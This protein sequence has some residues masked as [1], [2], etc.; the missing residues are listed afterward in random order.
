MITRRHIV[1]ALA[2]LTGGSTR[3]GT[4]AASSRPTETTDDGAIKSDEGPRSRGGLNARDFGARGD[5]RTDDTAALQAFIDAVTVGDYG[6]I[7]RGVY[8]VTEPLRVG[9][10]GEQRSRGFT[11]EGAGRTGYAPGHDQGGTLILL[12]TGEPA[13]AI[14]S[15]QGS[16]WRDAR[17]SNLGLACSQMDMARYGLLI[18][19]SEV[20]N[21]SFEHLSVERAET[22]FGHLQG[23]GR[24]GEFCSWS[25]IQ[26][27]HVKNF[28]FSDAGQALA[29]RFTNC[30]CYF[31][32]GGVLF[33]FAPTIQ[34][35]GPR[36]VNFDASPTQADAG[37][38][39]ADTTLFSLSDK[40]RA[41][42]VMVGGRIEH[43][44][45]IVELDTPSNNLLL[46]NHLQFIGCDFTTD[47]IASG[48][49]RG[50][51]TIRIGRS[52]LVSLAFVNC[53]FGHAVWESSGGIFAIAAEEGSRGSIRFE[54]C[55]FSLFAEKPRCALPPSSDMRAI[56]NDCFFNVMGQGEGARSLAYGERFEQMIVSRPRSN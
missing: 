44:T 55:G 36:L 16:A 31:R 2:L 1:S 43:I 51:A 40:H 52:S 5:G 50:R 25:D 20:S 30:F 27:R 28:F 35:G 34:G 10:S 24:N 14:I 23:E 6:Y 19:S 26:T 18:V 33:R 8:R 11:I 45:T 13:E 49:D 42:I 56:W 32:A 17:L 22:A 4:G 48:A 38:G 3:V 41:P 9:G 46:H 7:P 15:W 54:Q 37:D 47:L 39:M 21:L 29:P 53:S 12:D